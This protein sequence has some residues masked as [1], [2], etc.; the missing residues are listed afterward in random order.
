MMPRER[1]LQQLQ[2]PAVGAHGSVEA[3]RLIKHHVVIL[4]QF[5]HYF[6]KSDERILSSSYPNKTPKVF[7]VSSAQMRGHG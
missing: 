5:F 4:L 7:Q 3:Q 6:L 2:L 1:S